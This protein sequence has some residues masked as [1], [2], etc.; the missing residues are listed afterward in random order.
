MEE[1]I[2]GPLL[3]PGGRLTRHRV[4]GG[5]LQLWRT[6]WKPGVV[7]KRD[8]LRITENSTGD[9]SGFPEGHCYGTCVRVMPG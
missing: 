8:N 9:H 1:W 4:T 7:T 2:G 6:S 3:L 5:Q